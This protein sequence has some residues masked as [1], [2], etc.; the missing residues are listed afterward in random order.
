MKEDR[1][2]RKEEEEEDNGRRERQKKGRGWGGEKQ[3]GRGRCSN[4]PL[5]PVT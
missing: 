2:R 3:E 4:D 5:L 1:R